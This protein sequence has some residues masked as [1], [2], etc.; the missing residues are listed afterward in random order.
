[1]PTPPFDDQMILDCVESGT[2][3]YLNG[4]TA[5]VVAVTVDEQS[6]QPV[7]AGLLSLYAKDALITIGLTQ[8][9]TRPQEGG[10]Y[11]AA[12]GV[13]WQLVSVLKRT[14]GNFW[15]ITGRTFA[16]PGGLTSRGTLSRRLN[17]ATT[18]GLYRTTLTPY[19]SAAACRFI[20]DGQTPTLDAERAV[21]TMLSGVVVMEGFRDMRAGDVWRD[22]SAP[23]VLWDV[24][25]VDPRDISLGAQVFRVTREA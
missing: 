24:N 3:T 13:V 9:P 2:V 4:S 6:V 12:D 8:C 14:L 19:V 5:A 23:T 17:V 20:A 11:T 18:T 7:Q 22:D 16:V 21:K 25:S 15:E 1:M 10:T